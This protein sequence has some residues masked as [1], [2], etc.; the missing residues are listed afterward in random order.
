MPITFMFL[1]FISFPLL[2]QCS[3]DCV[4][5]C[6][7]FLA[8]LA[9]G[10]SVGECVRCGVYVG[11]VIVQQSGFTLP[12]TPDFSWPL[13]T[14]IPGI[15]VIA[16]FAV[17][18]KWFCDANSFS[19][20]WFFFFPFSPP[21]IL[22]IYTSECKFRLSVCVC[23]CVCVLFFCWCVCVCVCVCVFFVCMCVCVFSLF[24]G[25]CVYVCVCVCVCVRVC[26]CVCDHVRGLPFEQSFF[27]KQFF[28][29]AWNNVSHMTE[30]MVKYVL[31]VYSVIKCDALNTTVHHL[32]LS[33]QVSYCVCESNCSGQIFVRI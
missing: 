30:K 6:A 7:G 8:Q 3:V 32:H 29:H 11:N 13:H 15:L 26:V 14:Y 21:L 1:T 31:V 12:D 23:V 10:K 17:S 9:Q 4:C 16:V 27:M 24:A 22:C 33:W 20:F 25:V 28:V 18:V 19:S 2:S 5:M